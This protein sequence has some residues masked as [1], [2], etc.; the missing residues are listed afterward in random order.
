MIV[1][2]PG[3]TLWL[4]R[5]ELRLRWRGVL[6]GQGARSARHLR[7]L[8]IGTLG[9][10]V[11]LVMGLSIGRDLA[12]GVFSP[13]DELLAS[14]VVLMFVSL[15]MLSQALG[16][17]IDELYARGD[18]EWMMTAPVPVRR[19]LGVRMLG[20]VAG[21]TWPWLLVLGPFALGAAISGRLGLLSVFP[22]LLALGGMVSALGTTVAVYLTSFFGLARTR[23]AASMLSVLAGTLGFVA[24]PIIPAARSMT[25]QAL[26]A[27]GQPEGLAWWPARAL[28]GD[29]LPLA[30]A[31]VAG[32]GAATLA[33]RLLEDRFVRG[34]TGS[35][36]LRVRRSR[37]PAVRVHNPGW[38]LLW[39]ELRRL[40]R[41]AGLWGRAAQFLPMLLPGAVVIWRGDVAPAALGLL[42]VFAA[43]GL[44]RL[45]VTA[46]VSGDEAAELAL[47][48]PIPVRWV[49][50]AKLAASA[51]CVGMVLGLPM[52]VL[53]MWRPG[54]VLVVLAGIMAALASALLIGLWHPGTPR[55]ADLGLAGQ[56]L[57]GRVCGFASMTACCGATMLALQHSWWSALPA[58]LVL[59]SLVVARPPG[60][61]E[62]PVS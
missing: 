52:M 16:I 20:M 3:S 34:V 51:L 19:M 12:R 28:L 10:G 22:V 62:E 33:G 27:A 24:G 46:S 59:V 15:L 26:N 4:L 5:H 17:A 37:A 55:R 9:G 50:R 47:T 58:A 40:W 54:D 48:A 23:T 11:A 18:L 49:H 45:F 8:T 56:S 30:A 14:N 29:H 32:L 35:F 44:G 7:L 13:S 36:P 38:T 61:A 2:R 6:P 41:M 21:I 39:T 57:L 42:P 60:W 53:G 31:V 25:E 1:L 43:A